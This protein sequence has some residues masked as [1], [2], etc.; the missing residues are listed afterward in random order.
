M[1]KVMAICQAEIERRGLHIY[2]VGDDRLGVRLPNGDE[3]SLFLDYDVDVEEDEVGDGG[4]WTTHG[5]QVEQ[6]EDGS[7]LL[8]ACLAAISV[9][10][11]GPQITD[12]STDGGTD[13][14]E[15][16]FC[17][18]GDYVALKVR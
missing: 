3:I 4:D 5:M 9:S 11:L 15:A 13:D 16:I 18:D 10:P 6:I 8:S 14:C 12:I 17:W 7:D 1:S 2:D